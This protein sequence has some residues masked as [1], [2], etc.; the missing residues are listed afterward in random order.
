[1]SGN[2]LI[3]NIF[4]STREKERGRWRKLHCEELHGSYSSL[5]VWWRDKFLQNFGGET[6]SKETT[7]KT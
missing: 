6:W 1:M 3:R 7:W 5:H 4:E 2:R